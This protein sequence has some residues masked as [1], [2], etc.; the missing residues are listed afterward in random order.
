MAEIKTVC[1]YCGTGCGVLLEDR[2]NREIALRGDPSHPANKGK[3]CTKGA[4][5]PLTLG[6][7]GR[8]LYP[9]L[10]RERGQPRQRA[11][12][13]ES[14][15]YLAER[16][17]AIARRDGPESIGFYVSGQLLSED[18]YAF[19]KLARGLVGTPHIDSN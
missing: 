5:L 15:D 7:Q 18:Y 6:L 1:C 3:L 19:N 14:L 11:G 17:A 13:D 4:A 8:A 2:G 10:R 12:W 16:F 9:E